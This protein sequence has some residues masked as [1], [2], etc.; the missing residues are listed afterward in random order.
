M[1]L[2][3]KCFWGTVARMK[4]E[5]I[6]TSLAF[7]LVGGSLGA[8][9]AVRWFK[10]K[11]ESVN[12]ENLAAQT[13]LARAEA[14]Q[15]QRGQEI[16]HLNALLTAANTEKERLQGDLIEATT[17]G[18]AVGERA[19]RI[20]ELEREIAK[21]EQQLTAAREE[22]SQQK[23]ALARLNAQFE[24]ERKAAE[25]K[26]AL[27]TRAKEELGLQFKAL[28]AEA[29]QSNNQSFL[30]L[31]KEALGKFQQSAQ[32][33]LTS[34]QKA[35]DEVVKP[36][37]ESL[38][39]VDG[40]IALIETERTRAYASLTQQVGSMAT[41]QKQLQTETAN[42]VQA[43]RSPQVRGRWGEIQLKR[44]VEI[45]GMLE[46]C[47]FIQQESVTTDEGRLRP[48]LIVKLP[49]SKNIIVDAK[50]PLQAYLDALATT[51]ES[52]RLALLRKH[53]KQVSEHISKLSTK[54]YWTQF[55]AAPEFVFLFLPGEAFFSAALEQ[56]PTLIETGA[57]SR[58][59]LA[60]P[61]TLIALLRAVSHGWRQ[62]RIAENAQAISNL[63]RELH[64]RLR[65]FAEHV[66]TIGER[67]GGA[68]QAYN[69][70]AG[71]LEGRVLVTARKLK[72]IGGTVDKEIELVDCI[73]VL[74]RP[75]QLPP[76]PA[77]TE[78]AV[79]AS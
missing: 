65:V 9:F 44:V 15:E 19:N 28:S 32:S 18:A 25:E 22:L 45:A 5:L 60:T 11:L 17:R 39:K 55:D 8:F 24:E 46:H 71:S 6:M 12:A 73:E 16:A 64:D 41:T 2:Q 38:Q 79:G 52:A 10:S 58:V 26:L 50:C 13:G 3:F 56:D 62:E 14:L 35:I 70:A 53:A 66:G 4:Y 7:V 76:L 51:D 59:I 30:D 75:L 42:L 72:E 31:A 78:S 43:L 27:V 40:Q 68:V 61:T 34:R 29:L 49:G 1:R 48:D 63:G 37:K 74:P 57:D 77:A 21:Q 47:D 69:K 20:P 54:A 67:L 23:E 36:L 33:D